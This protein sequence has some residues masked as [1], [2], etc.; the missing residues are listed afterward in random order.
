MY[1]IC[2]CD[3]RKFEVNL[4]NFEVKYKGRQNFSSAHFIKFFKTP[5]I[6]SS[7]YSQ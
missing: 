2:P 4:L 6:I 3:M 1:Q 7:E 5:Q